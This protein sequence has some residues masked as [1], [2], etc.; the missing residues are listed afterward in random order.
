MIKHFIDLE[1]Y[2]QKELRYILNFAKKIKKNKKK[3]SAILK[4]KSL[5]LIFEKQSTRTR[6]SFSIGMHKIGGNVV[7]INPD[8]IGF[9]TRESDEDILRVMAQYIDVLM[10]RND[11]HQRLQHLSSF[12]I[13]P[14]INGLSNLSHPCQILSDIFTIEEIFGNIK[15]LKI[16]W[17][18][19]FNNVLISLIQAAEIFKFKLNLLTPSTYKK[20]FDNLNKKKN[21]KY[22]NFLSNFDL[23]IKNSNCIMTDTWVSMGE[24]NSKIK[25][26]L[27]SKF[28]VDNNIMKKAEKNA[29]FMHCLPAHRGEEVTNSVIDGPQSVVW[30]QTL[31]RMFVQQSILYYLIENVKK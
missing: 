1:N 30:Q 29:I 9:G 13:L 25:K 21:F 5:G 16:T 6:L 3:F 8:Q 22:T 17:M 31:N 12:N 24:K 20:D 23:A 18:G 11:D 28:Q 7:E 27:L 2:N 19:D 26:N 15:N 10:I 14:I 4:N